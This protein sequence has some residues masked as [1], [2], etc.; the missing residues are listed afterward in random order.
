MDDKLI[1]NNSK[2]SY[3]FKKLQFLGIFF[4]LVVTIGC[5]GGGSGGSASSSTVSKGVGGSMSRFAIIGDYLYT[6]SGAD[7]QLFDITAASN[8]KPWSNVTL[9]FDIET[10]FS[11][12]SSLFVGSQTGIHIYDT[13][14]PAFPEYKS[15]LLHLRSCD[16]VVVQGIYAYSTLRN[17]PDCVGDSNQLDIIDVSDIAAPLLV[18][19]YPMQEPK[20]LAIDNEKLFVCDGIAGLKVFDASNP[21]DLTNLDFLASTSCYDLIAN[22]GLLIVSGDDGLSQFDYGSIPNFPMNQLSFISYT[23]G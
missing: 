12:N 13:S 11:N 4:F 1:H 10:L 14:S 20:G 8:P 18:K 17:N 15:K 21:M 7:I 22:N 2:L 16:P 5:A 6:I 23:S 19:S 3:Y 9:D